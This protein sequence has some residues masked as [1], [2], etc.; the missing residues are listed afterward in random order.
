MVSRHPPRIADF[1][2]T[3][4]YPLIIGIVKGESGHSYIP[5]SAHHRVIGQCGHHIF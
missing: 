1:N 4:R 3:R 2:P 5:V